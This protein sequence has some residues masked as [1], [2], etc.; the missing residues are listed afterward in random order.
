[1]MTR[2]R[3]DV[4]LAATATVAGA[5]NL[6][7]PAIA[8]GAKELTMVTSWSKN[9]AGMQ[10]SADRL[11]HTITTM[12]EGRLKVSVY[13]DGSLVH[14]Y[15]V[16]DAVGAG[17]ADMYHTGEGV[18]ES[19][20]PALNFFCGTVPYGLTA[21]ELCAWINFGGGQPLWDD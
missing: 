9:S 14:A 18:F 16:F 4:L 7:A 19:K 10:T 15:E 3:R 8:Q 2:R 6:T 12:S 1:M 20:S 5:G 17:A 13:P 11:A 21:D